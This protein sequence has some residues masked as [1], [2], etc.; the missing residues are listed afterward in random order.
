MIPCMTT[1]VL[2]PPCQRCGGMLVPNALVCTRCGGFT[3]RAELDRLSREATSLE[4]FDPYGAIVRWRRCLEL[5]PP[6]SQQYAAIYNRLVALTSAYSPPSSQPIATA[7]EDSP[8][9]ALLKTGGSML[10]SIVVYAG[11]ML[12]GGM[13]LLPALLM[14]SGIV[15]LI[16]VHELGHVAAMRYYGLSASPPIFIP[17][18]GALINLRQRPQNAKVEAIVGIGGPITGTVGAL[19]CYGLYLALPDGSPGQEM[20]K[21]LAYAGFLLNLFN[22]LPVPPLDGGRITAALN[23]KIWMLGVGGLVAMVVYELRQGR[24]P[25]LLF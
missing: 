3:H 24:T 9:N 23:P 18:V 17:F 6:D 15:I 1:Q 2:S 11:L 22:L 25:F 14:S 16:L 10:V 5:L 19:A 8:G 13:P 7:A 4:P 12:L 21:F 20:T